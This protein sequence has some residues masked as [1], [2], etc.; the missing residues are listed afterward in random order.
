MITFGHV[1]SPLNLT[2]TGEANNVPLP[3]AAGD[4]PPVVFFRLI[5]DITSVLIEKEL[6]WSGFV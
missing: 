5:A 6:F 1:N 3:I 4:G 2:S